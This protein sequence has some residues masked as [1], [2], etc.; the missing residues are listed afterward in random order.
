MSGDDLYYS[1]LLLVDVTELD[2]RDTR[3]VT[4]PHETLGYM[5]DARRLTVHRI[6]DYNIKIQFRYTVSSHELATI[7]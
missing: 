6:Y 2:E 5:R 7:R 4:V 3:Y 1:Q